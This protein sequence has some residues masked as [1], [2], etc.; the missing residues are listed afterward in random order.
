MQLHV[1]KISLLILYHNHIILSIFQP[2]AHSPI[3]NL[4]DLTL[5]PAMI[6][7]LEKGLN[8][9]PSPGELNFGDLMS[10]MQK[11]HRNLRLRTFFGKEED[12]VSNPNDSNVSDLAYYPGPDSYAGFGHRLFKNKSTFNPKGP[13]TLE[14]FIIQNETSLARIKCRSPKTNNITRE[15]KCALTELISNKQIV[16]KK[17]DKGSSIV[18]QNTPD[19][20][21]ESIK[22]LNVAEHYR[23]D[24]VCQTKFHNDKI[25]KFLDL[26]L[27]AEEITSITHDYLVNKKP[28]TPLL[29]TQPK[30]HKGVLPPPCRPIVSGNDSPS[31]R[32][33]QFVDFFL[34]PIVPKIPSYIKDTTHFLKLIEDL[35]E[36]PE[37][38]LLATLDVSALYTNIPQSEGISACLRALELTRDPES[39]PSHSSIAHLLKLVLSTNNFEFNSIN[40]TQIS[41]TAMGTKLAPSYANIFMAQFEHKFVY[42]HRDKFLIWWRYIDDIFTIFECDTPSVTAFV[43]DLNH[44]HPTIKFTSEISDTSINFLDATITKVGTKLLCKSYTKPTDSHN[45]LLYSSCHPHHCKQGL[46]YSQFLRIRRLCS[47][48]TD[49]ETKVQDMASHFIRRGYPTELVT[50]AICKAREQ[51]RTMLLNPPPKL[52]SQPQQTFLITTFHPQYSEFRNVIQT[53]W[54]MLGKSGYTSDIFEHKYI[55]GYKRLPNLKDKLVN[56]RVPNTTAPIAK[57]NRPKPGKKCKRALKL[58]CRYC[59]KI[60]HSGRITSTFSGREYSAKIN[61]DCK[62]TNLIY[63]ITCKKCKIQYVGQTMI[64][65]CKRFNTHFNLIANGSDTH[66]VSKHFSKPDHKGLRDVEIHIVDFI[67]AKPRSTRAKKLRDLIETNWIHRLR[68]QAPIG[69]NIEV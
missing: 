30:I 44:C 26:M 32:I 25:V 1:L 51:D 52:K 36:I 28:R 69:L 39:M 64:G 50:N 66:S 10:D 9:C 33:S 6:S 34:K 37:N 62:S 56:A 7:L 38:C 27:E 35:G 21:S 31:E 68:T 60:N 57:P 59:P 15:E 13:P 46:P 12:S 49:F 4:S 58:K 45:Y 17:A 67:H 18:I 16:I 2:P 14:A 65:L 23:Q 41:G 24:S 54:E 48:I 63:C 20:I 61:V 19:Y 22:L 3:V 5:T 55:T 40:Y 8:F 53:N 43:N 42:P 47:N 11:F 29:Y